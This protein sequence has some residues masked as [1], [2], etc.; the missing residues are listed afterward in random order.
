MSDRHDVITVDLDLV[1]VMNK[2]IITYATGIWV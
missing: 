1:Y 2:S